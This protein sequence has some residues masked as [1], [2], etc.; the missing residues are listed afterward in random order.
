MDL[1]SKHELKNVPSKK[2]DMIFAFQLDYVST[3]ELTGISTLRSNEL[4]AISNA[5]SSPDGKRSAWT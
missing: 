2:S 1:L 3:D 4:H 5:S